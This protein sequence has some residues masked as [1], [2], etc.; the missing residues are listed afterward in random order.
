MLRI[1]HHFRIIFLA[2]QF[3]FIK[4]RIFLR[5]EKNRV[6]INPIDAARSACQLCKNPRLAAVRI[7]QP[8]LYRSRI[9]LCAEA[10]AIAGERHQLSVGRPLRLSIVVA[11]ARELN[12]FVFGQ[13]RQN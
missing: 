5:A 11:A 6:F 10:R 2:L 13:A 4:R 1:I 8:D 3:L 9:R 12:F 7:D